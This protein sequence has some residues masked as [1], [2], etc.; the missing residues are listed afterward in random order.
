[1]DKRASEP[2]IP[3]TMAPVCEAV[4]V[5]ARVAAGSSLWRT[6]RCVNV[7]INVVIRTLLLLK[8]DSELPVH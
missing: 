1:M 3:P 8:R 2:R 5:A 6:I 4:F 7:G